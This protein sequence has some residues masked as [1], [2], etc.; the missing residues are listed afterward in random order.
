VSCEEK[1]YGKVCARGAN[2]LGEGEEGGG[3]GEGM[4]RTKHARTHAPFV[5]FD[6]PPIDA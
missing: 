2:S 5:P 1:E 4:P 3:G 6:L